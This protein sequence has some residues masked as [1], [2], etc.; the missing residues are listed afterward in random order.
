LINIKIK[1]GNTINVIATIKIQFNKNNSAVS[2][3]LS[4]GGGGGTYPA[5]HAS[6]WQLREQKA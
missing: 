6:C 3:G 4:F 1:K 2:R 5:F